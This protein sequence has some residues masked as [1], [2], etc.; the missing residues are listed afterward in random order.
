LSACLL[1]GLA[2]L[3]LATGCA[4]VKPWERELHA[5]DDMGW[6]TNGQE[7]QRMSHIFFSKEAAMP[8][9]SGGGGGCGCN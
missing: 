4:G 1:S 2:V 6:G 8:A 7:A 5:R 9:G 3:L